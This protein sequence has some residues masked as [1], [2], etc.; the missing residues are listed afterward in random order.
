[1]E[2]IPVDMKNMYEFCNNEGCRGG[3]FWKGKDIDV[4]ENS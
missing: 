2:N 1:M 4:N 3:T